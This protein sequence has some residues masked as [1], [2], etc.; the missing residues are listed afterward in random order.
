MGIVE[1]KRLRERSD[2]CVPNVLARVSRPVARTALF[3][4][5]IVFKIDIESWGH[6]RA[7][8]LAQAQRVWLRCRDESI[9]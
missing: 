3:E 4:R 7:E 6:S 1:R 2:W 9:R 5:S 8:T